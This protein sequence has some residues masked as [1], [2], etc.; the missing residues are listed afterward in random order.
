[1]GFSIWLPRLVNN[2][3]GPSHPNSVPSLFTTRWTGIKATLS[4][5]VKSQ[6]ITYNHTLKTFE[7]LVRYHFK[8][9]LQI[10]SKSKSQLFFKSSRPFLKKLPLHYFPAICCIHEA[11]TNTCEKFSHG[12]R[13]SHKIDRAAVVIFPVTFLGFSIA[14]WVTYF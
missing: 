6:F 8:T 12:E 7:S 3:T 13:I 14:Y 2:N 9:Y 11:E 5:F 4:I 10:C 1:M